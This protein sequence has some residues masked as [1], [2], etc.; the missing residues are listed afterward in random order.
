MQDK[1]PLHL[2]IITFLKKGKSHSLSTRNTKKVLFNG[3]L[4]PIS[5]NNKQVFSFHLSSSLYYNL[6]TSLECV[7][8]SNRSVGVS[9][10]QYALIFVY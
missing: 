2:S 8:K 6:L 10:L 4:M 3:K 7:I 5:E 1:N 9:S